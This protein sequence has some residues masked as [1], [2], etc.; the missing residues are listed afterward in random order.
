VQST[1][2]L[3]R[4]KEWAAGGKL[5]IALDDNPYDDNVAGEDG[6][7]PKWTLTLLVEECPPDLILL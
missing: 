3:A 5:G 4:A 2:L 7:N 6:R 1:S